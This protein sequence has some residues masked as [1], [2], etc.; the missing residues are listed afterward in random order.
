MSQSEVALIKKLG[1][2]IEMYI[3]EQLA[4]IAKER[5]WA[6]YFTKDA[7]EINAFKHT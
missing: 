5:R 4:R 7:N 3:K 6:W 2:P 1:I